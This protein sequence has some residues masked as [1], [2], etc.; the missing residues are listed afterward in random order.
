ME[1]IVSV[2]NCFPLESFPLQSLPVVV[3]SKGNEDEEIRRPAIQVSGSMDATW[4]DC[5]GK[6]WVYDGNLTEALRGLLAKLLAWNRDVFGSIFRRKHR[7]KSMLEGVMN[8][9]NAAPTLGLMKLEE[10]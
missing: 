4:G 9:I 1:E 10:V 6:E 7:V 3:G 5:I 2:G 8:A